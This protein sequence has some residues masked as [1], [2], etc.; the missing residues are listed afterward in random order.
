MA[1]IEFA[2][3]GGEGAPSVVETIEVLPWWA[4]AGM[5]KQQFSLHSGINFNAETN[6][7]VEII[8]VRFI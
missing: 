1:K 6:M 8:W 2:Y 5:A 7:W 4:L 3:P